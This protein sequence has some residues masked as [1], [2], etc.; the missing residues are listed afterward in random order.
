MRELAWAL[1]EDKRYR[2]RP[3][4]PATTAAEMSS[5]RRR[6]TEQVLDAVPILVTNVMIVKG[7]G[8]RFNKLVNALPLMETKL[9][10]RVECWGRSVGHVVK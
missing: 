8:C 1:A 10:L 6:I 3:T 5:L 4:M 9:Y 2:Y 7:F